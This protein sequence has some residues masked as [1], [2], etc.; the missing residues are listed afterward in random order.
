MQYEQTP[1]NLIQIIY[2]VYMY[3]SKVNFQAYRSTF[4]SYDP[5]SNMLLIS[6]NLYNN[7]PSLRIIT[8]LRKI[9]FFVIYLQNLCNFQKPAHSSSDNIV[10]IP[11]SN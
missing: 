9:I 2:V 3:L 1:N 6:Y 7:I 5:F 4:F 10:C 11:T 8:R